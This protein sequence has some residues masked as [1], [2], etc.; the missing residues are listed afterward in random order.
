M[1]EECQA[2]KGRLFGK[3]DTRRVPERKASCG[4]LFSPQ[5]YTSFVRNPQTGNMMLR[6][7]GFGDRLRRDKFQ[8]SK[9]G[10]CDTLAFEDMSPS[11]GEAT[12]PGSQCHSGA[13]SIAT[14]YCRSVFDPHNHHPQNLTQPPS[15]LHN[16]PVNWT[17]SCRRRGKQREPPVV[18]WCGLESVLAVV[19]KA[20]LDNC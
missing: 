11:Q 20:L 1:I 9:K 17:V 15:R 7:L 14:H 12:L 4:F 13:L 2:A 6:A 10:F 5:S 16:P 19:R 8:W 3:A 18:I